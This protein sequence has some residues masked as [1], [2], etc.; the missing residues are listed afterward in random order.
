MFDLAVL[1]QAWQHALD[2]YPKE[3][4]GLIIDNGTA[5]VR[6][7]NIHE[8]PKNNFR[9]HT[10]DFLEYLQAGR[11]SAFMHSHTGNNPFPSRQDMVLQENMA[12]PW[13]IT[14]ISPD[15]DIDGPFFFGDQVPIAP[16]LE[17]NFRCGVH[18]CYTLLRD[19]Y[20]QELDITLPIFPRQG[21]WWNSKQ[22]LLEENFKKAGFKQIDRTQLRKN[23]VLLCRVNSPKD[24]P[25]VNH[26]AIVRE[27][28]QIIHHMLKRLS[29][30]APIQTW[31]G[32]AVSFLRYDGGEE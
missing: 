9:M 3:S 13:G 7:R 32:T 18:D 17:R 2:E 21:E 27:R 28:G 12:L 30:H 23:D 4:C 10:P 1:Q 29:C 11:I 15:K 26:I 31:I 8:S 24:N 25:V 14:Y 16:L 6:M 19:I 22:N 20:R 5:Y